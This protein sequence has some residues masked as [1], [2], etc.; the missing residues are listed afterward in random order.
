MDTAAV[1]ANLAG[2]EEEEAG[3]GSNGFNPKIDLGERF[4]VVL[5]AP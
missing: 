1:E 5:G 2:A 3:A 4:L